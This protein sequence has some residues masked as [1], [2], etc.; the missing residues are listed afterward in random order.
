[1]PAFTITTQAVAGQTLNGSEVGVVTQTGSILDTTASSGVQLTADFA[2]L[3]NMGTITSTLSN[4]I[5]GLGATGLRVYNSGSINSMNSAIFN[6]ATTAGTFTIV[7]TGEL[8]GIGDSAAGVRLSSGGLRLTNSGSILSSNNVAIDIQAG[9]AVE[10]NRIFN[11]GTISGGGGTAILMSSDF[12]TVIN[13]GTIIGDV[14]L[15]DNDDRFDGRGGTVNG[16]VRGETGNDLYLIDDGRIDILEFSGQG[17]D[18]VEAW[19][20]YSLGDEIEML[21]LRGSAVLGNGNDLGNTLVGNSVGNRM[22]GGLGDDTIEGLLGDDTLRGEDGLD[23]LS[24]GNGNDLISG[25]FGVDT[26]N[27]N[28]G[29]DTL[30][31]GDAGDRMVAGSG[32]DVLI[33]GAG[34]DQLY[35]GVGGDTFVFGSVDDIGLVAGTR[36]RIFDFEAGVDEIDLRAIDANLASAADNAFVLV[37]ALT[38]TA[39]QVTL[40]VAGGNGFLE[41][42]V[43]G[44]GVA[45]FSL[46]L[47]GVTA[48]LATDLIL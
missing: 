18:T 10:A 44:D 3:Y 12:D 16:Q 37:G 43:N 28:G 13:A 1:M 4:G 30:F 33:G 41:G 15:G 21:R 5:S 27:G 31:G 20:D 2:V 11:T 45:D 35:G 26:L 19:A 23:S 34:P 29:D 39:G 6:A 32:D 48:I 42:D 25:E 46:Q 17:T 7:N 47:N 38:G 22:E 9:A 8:V 24:G 14:R 36:D 40:R